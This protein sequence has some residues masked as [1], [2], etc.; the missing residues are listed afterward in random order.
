MAKDKEFAM[1]VAEKLGGNFLMASKVIAMIIKKKPSS[2]YECVDSFLRDT[3]IQW[4]YGIRIL[5]NSLSITGSNRVNKIALFDKLIEGK[6][7]GVYEFGEIFGLEEVDIME[8]C[9]L[10]PHVLYFNKGSLQIKYSTMASTV[11]DV[12]SEYK[13]L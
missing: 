2:P 1:Y 6:E 7:V 8:L 11:R 5:L 4:K 9:K 3:S 13:Q 12:L 10:R